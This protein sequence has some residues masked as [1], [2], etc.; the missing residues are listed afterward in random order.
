[1]KIGQL[2]SAIIYIPV[3]SQG[4]GQVNLWTRGRPMAGPLCQIYPFFIGSGTWHTI[5][6]AE[7]HPHSPQLSTLES[8]YTIAANMKFQR[9]I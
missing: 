1:M 5:A 4:K 7:T 8:Q 2:V 9:F 3:Y 6:V